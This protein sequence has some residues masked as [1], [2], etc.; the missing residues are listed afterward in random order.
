[1][2]GSVISDIFPPRDRAAAM[3]LYVTGP[4]LG[5]VLGPIAG[6]FTSQ[7]LGYEWVFI[8]TSI[9]SGAAGIYGIF[10]LRETYHPIL[11]RRL[12]ERPPATGPPGP[13]N[14][15]GKKEV[16]EEKAPATIQALIKFVEEPGQ[17]KMETK[18]IIYTNMTRPFALFFR[19][20]ILFILGLFLA[21]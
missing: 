8:I 1:M 7:H 13:S 18:E 14:G 17:R 2:G 16:D 19:S 21:M 11:R 3:A 9:L 12:I 4:L 6:G 5:P 15:G 10:A 20:F